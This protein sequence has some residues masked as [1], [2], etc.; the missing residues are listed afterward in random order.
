MGGAGS[1]GGTTIA[2]GD[3]PQG[4]AVGPDGKIYVVNSGSGTLSVIDPATNTVIKTYTLGGDTPTD[5][6]VVTGQGGTDWVHFVGDSYQSYAFF[7][8]TNP[9]TIYHTSIG[10]WPTALA[11]N[12]EGYIFITDI[13]KVPGFEDSLYIA[14]PGGDLFAPRWLGYDAN[15]VAV[16]VSEAGPNDGYVYV[17][18]SGTSSVAVLMPDL[19]LY[20]ISLPGTTPAG[21]AVN[22]SG[23]IYVTDSANNTLLV[24]TPT[25]VG[26]QVNHAI[27][28]TIPVGLQPGGVAV[29]PDG[30]IYVANLGSNTLSV[31]D[32]VTNTVT[33][34][35]AVGDMSG[36]IVVGS[37]GA[38]YLTNGAH[39]RLTIIS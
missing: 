19:G 22:N 39:D 15:P 6:V 28:A 2:V 37:N 33:G 26:F 7:D 25:E 12:S 21:I 34:T 36:D 16:A 10:E 24:I 13:T 31:I 23:T 3:N 8:T 11:A 18:N 14:G 27:T 1:G 32:P 29:G 17:A 4:L 20:T 5:A 35:V 30:T 9:N 38:V